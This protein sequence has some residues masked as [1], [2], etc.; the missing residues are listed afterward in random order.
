MGANMTPSDLLAGLAER[1]IVLD[2]HEGSLRFRPKS[3]VGPDLLALIRQHKGA[4]LDLLAIPPRW[5]EYHDAI[6]WAFAN[7]TTRE[8]IG[9]H[10]MTDPDGWPG[11]RP[12]AA[13]PAPGICERCGSDQH[14]DFPIHGGRSIRRDCAQCGR[15]IG[16]SRWQPPKEPR[17][18]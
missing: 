1:G 14:K 16:F 6:A 8:E 3:A 12:R 9:P 5:D 18:W 4:L 11:S 15:T 7:P 13:K 2:A 10:W 17:L